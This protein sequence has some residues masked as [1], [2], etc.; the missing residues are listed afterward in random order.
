MVEY[1]FFSRALGTCTKMT[2]FWAKKQVSITIK[3]FK[4]YKVNGNKLIV[5]DTWENLKYM[6]SK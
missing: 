3:G 5:T 4:S 1:T 2:T 6:E